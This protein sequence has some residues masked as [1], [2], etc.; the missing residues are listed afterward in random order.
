MGKLW[1]E[2][3]NGNL[4]HLNVVGNDVNSPDDAIKVPV[5]LISI[6]NRCY[7]EQIIIATPQL[8]TITIDL[9]PPG[10]IGSCVQCGHCCSHLVANCPR[11]EGCGWPYRSDIDAH[12]CQHLVVDKWRKWPEAGNTSCAMHSA[13]LDYS[14][15]CAYPLSIGEINPLWINCGY[16]I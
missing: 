16:S 9:R 3:S 2:K 14:K 7:G 15:G 10:I 6:A 8:G 5:N 13:I 4:I 12:A 1:V 11:P